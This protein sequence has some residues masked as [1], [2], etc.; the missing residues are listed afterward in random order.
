[1][2]RLCCPISFLAYRKGAPHKIHYKH[3]TKGI[4]AGDSED[5]TPHSSLCWNDT[6][7]TMKKVQ[8]ENSMIQENSMTE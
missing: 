6:A 1:M 4:S 5:I 3:W 7:Y 2:P 8:W